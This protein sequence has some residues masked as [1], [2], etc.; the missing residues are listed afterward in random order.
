MIKME[1]WGLIEGESEV[2]EEEGGIKIKWCGVIDWMKKKNWLGEKDIYRGGKNKRMSM[3]S[4]C[5]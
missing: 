5:G 2:D 4:C 3:Y 1:V